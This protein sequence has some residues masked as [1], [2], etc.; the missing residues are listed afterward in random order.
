MQDNRRKKIKERE[1]VA[2]AASYMQKVFIRRN[3]K[4]MEKVVNQLRRK[5]NIKKVKQCRAQG[6]RKQ[7]E[8]INNESVMT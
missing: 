2:A 8:I 4:L 5:L 7:T 6:R 3:P 1:T